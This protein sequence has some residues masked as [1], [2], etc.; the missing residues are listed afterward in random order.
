MKKIAIFVEGQTELIFIRKLILLLFSSIPLSFECLQLRAGNLNKIPYS[1]INEFSQIHFMIINVEGDEKVLSAIIE[2]E[3][4]ITK[5]GYTKIIG[6]RDMYSEQYKKTCGKKINKDCIEKHIQVSNDIICNRMANPENVSYHFSIM[7][8]ESWW[9][10]MHS[11][12]KEINDV[13]TTEKI[14]TIINCKINDIDPE[15]EF[16]RPSKIVALILS[17][18]GINNHKSETN[19]ESIVSKIT[20]EN[21]EEILLGERASSY[22]NLLQEL[23]Q[24]TSV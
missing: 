11:I 16:F 6:I 3:D 17:K 13:L 24:I 15:I 5:K 19:S 8:I 2:Y 22:K 1:T 4:K 10:A 18:I 9:L 20:I 12:F 23:K 21:I 14:S 7:E